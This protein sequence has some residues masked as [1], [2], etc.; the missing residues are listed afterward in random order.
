MSIPTQ[1][2]ESQPLGDAPE[3]LP[4]K[5]IDGMEPYAT[6]FER[7]PRAI[8]RR[9]EDP[10][11][12][13]LDDRNTPFTSWK[14]AQIVVSVLHNLPTTLESK[15]ERNWVVKHFQLREE[16]TQ[17]SDHIVL[18]TNG[19]V[20][21]YRYELGDEFVPVRRLDAIGKVSYAAH[22]DAG[23]DYSKKESTFVIV[24]PTN[25]ERICP[26]MDFSRH[27][28]TCIKTARKNRPSPSTPKPT[29]TVPAKFSRLEQQRRMLSVGRDHDDDDDDEEEDSDLYKRSKAAYQE[30]SVVP[31]ARRSS[32]DSIAS[33]MDSET[34]V[35]DMSSNQD[36][37]FNMAPPNILDEDDDVPASQA[38]LEIENSGYVRRYDDPPSDD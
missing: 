20:L 35:S 30:P 25:P 22:N 26:I 13:I 5:D 24:G 8:F 27:C 1:P 36:G 6:F 12:V 10:I 3:F 18:P 33:D 29:A 15:E 31:L 37:C 16:S 14:M 19:S 34:T 28:P 7:I 32:L 23:H 9:W 4:V 11:L 2:T 17:D 38:M 21:C